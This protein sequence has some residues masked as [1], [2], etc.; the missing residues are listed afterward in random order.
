[1]LRSSSLPD[2]QWAILALT[3]AALT[4]AVVAF[5]YW[6]Q[7]IVIP[8]ALA[9]FF[10]FVLAPV[11]ARVEALR[12]GRVF[13]VVSTVGLTL[14]MFAAVGWI[15][16]RQAASLTRSL[17]DHAENIKS[18]VLSAKAWVGADSGRRLG[19]LL[20]EVSELIAPAAPA[21]PASGQETPVKVVVAPPSPWISWV[22]PRA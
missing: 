11:V 9:V 15:L 21:A 17:P 18:K 5:L 16:G 13:A 20:D 4:A 14:I 10:T 2:W 6:A 12:L 8:F 19:S 22:G 3:A 1:M 7:A